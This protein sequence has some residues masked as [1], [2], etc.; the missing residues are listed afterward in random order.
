MLVLAATYHN[1]YMKSLVKKDDFQRL[2]ERTIEFLR[3]LCPISPTCKHD[4]SIL[5]KVHKLLFGI[6]PD[7]KHL[8]RNEGMIP[9]ALSAS[10]SFSAST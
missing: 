6:P 1:R 3:K 7:A 5:E 4:C 10:N 8:Y 9:E 2:L